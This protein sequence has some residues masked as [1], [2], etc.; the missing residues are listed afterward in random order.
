MFTNKQIPSVGA[1]IGIERIFGILEEKAKNDQNIR[2]NQTEVFIAT[3]GPGMVVPKMILASELWKQDIKAE[4]L[5]NAKPKPQKQIDYV[6][7]HLIPYMLWIGEDE[8]KA[9]QVKLKV[10]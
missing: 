10:C 1:S 7:E 8:V 4:F 6:H 9:N 3:V 2:Q 5:Y